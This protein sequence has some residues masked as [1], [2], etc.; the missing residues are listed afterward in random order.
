KDE[1]DFIK[2]ISNLLGIPEKTF[3]AIKEIYLKKGLK[4]E[5]EVKRRQ[6]G[7]RLNRNL[8]YLL[9]PY[10][11]YLI[12]GIPPSATVS[13]IKKAYRTLAKKHHP[14]KFAGQSEELIRKAEEK[15]QEIKEAYDTILKY[16]G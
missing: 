10:E 2:K 3:E 13:Q 11:A 16:K 4:D 5:E 7:R 9:V 12:L 1:N 6:T 14:D 8:S 15:F